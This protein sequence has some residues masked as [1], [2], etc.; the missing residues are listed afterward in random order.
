MLTRAEGG[1]PGVRSWSCQPESPETMSDG[2]R[3]YKPEGLWNHSA[4]MMIFTSEKEDPILR[5]TSALDRGS[6]KSKKGGKLS[7]HYNGDSST[8]ELPFR[9]II[10]VNQLSVY[11]AISDWCEEL[12]QQM[13]DHSFSSTGNSWRI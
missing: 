1:R 13:S 11:G 7:I 12:A 10:S 9:T 8:A 5:A 6:L 2:T 3:T 4:E